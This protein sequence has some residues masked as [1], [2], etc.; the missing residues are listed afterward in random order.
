MAGP[1][2]GPATASAEEA[3]TSLGRLLLDILRG[4]LRL[5]GFTLTSHHFMSPA[6]LQTEVGQARLAAC[7]FRLPYKEEMV[8]MCRMNAAGVREQFYAEIING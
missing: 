6:E 8:S 4:N 1:G 3:G 7:V 5:D 2:I